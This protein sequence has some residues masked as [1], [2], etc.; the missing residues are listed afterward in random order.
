MGLKEAVAQS[1]AYLLRDPMTE[2]ISAQIPDL[3]IMFAERSPAS[4]KIVDLG[5]NRDTARKALN[6][7][8]E[9]LGLALDD[10]DIDYLL[11]A[12][13]FDGPLVRNP[14]D[15]EL[16]MFAQISPEHCRVSG[17]GT[18]APCNM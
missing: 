6:E 4:L 14:T 11:D 17:S 7:I 1:I 3:T 2:T 18:F 12:Y 13:S 9:S 8:N 16:F 5:D 10:S 15:V